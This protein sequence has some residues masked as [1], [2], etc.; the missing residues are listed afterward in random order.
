MDQKYSI[1]CITCGDLI[2]Q[3]SISMHF[4]ENHD[5]EPGDKQKIMLEYTKIK[6]KLREIRRDECEHCG[7]YFRLIN[8]KRHAVACKANPKNSQQPESGPTQN[9][10]AATNVRPNATAGKA[11]TD[12]SLPEWLDRISQQFDVTVKLLGVSAD[13]ESQIWPEHL[14]NFTVSCRLCQED[15]LCCEINVHLQEKHTEQNDVNIRNHVELYT[16]VKRRLRELRRLSCRFCG[17]SVRYVNLPVHF[18]T[19]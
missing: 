13:D 5:A 16:K 6:R 7:K 15:V 4:K 14:Q 17:K 18:T 19:T 2:P 11:S 8:L 12:D 3:N 9:H 1:S 10:T